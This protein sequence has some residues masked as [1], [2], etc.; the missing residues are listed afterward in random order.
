M[1]VC[2]EAMRRS[3]DIIR[4]AM[5]KAKVSYRDVAS[6]IG[7]T[8]P[9]IVNWVNGKTIPADVLARQICNALGVKFETVMP[10]LAQERMEKAY[11]AAERKTANLLSILEGGPMESKL[12]LPHGKYIVR[13]PHNKEYTLSIERTAD[14]IIVH[15]VNE[16]GQVVGI[17][18]KIPD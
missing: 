13:G 5:N 8:H 16:K 6:R 7:C 10:L 1:A 17:D 2:L 15:G 9:S 14:G 12:H 4:N 3:G 11:R 18:Q